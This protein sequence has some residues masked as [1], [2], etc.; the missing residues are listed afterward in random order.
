M[1]KRA[2]YLPLDDTPFERHYD[3]AE[4]RA[5]RNERDRTIPDERDQPWY[6]LVA[7]IN[8]LI[9]SD[10]FDWAYDSLVGIRDTVESTRRVSEG[11][12]RAVDNIERAR[13]EPRR[14]GFRRR[15]EGWP[16]R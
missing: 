3:D 9:S 6:Q 11:Q 15:Y 8:D 16:R 12:R 7:R 1:G 14:D 4:A 2:D 13:R 5:D 10:E